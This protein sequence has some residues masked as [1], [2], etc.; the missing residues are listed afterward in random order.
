MSAACSAHLMAASWA[1][2]WAVLMVSQLAAWRAVRSD[3]KMAVKSET[4]LTGE[5]K[6]VRKEQSMAAQKGDYWAVL[7]VASRAPQM[8]DPLEG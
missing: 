2:Y 4:E 7:R 5:P 1:G 3:L 8:A 6:V